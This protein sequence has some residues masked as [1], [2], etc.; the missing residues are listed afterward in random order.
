MTPIEFRLGGGF[1]RHF[2]PPWGGIAIENGLLDAEGDVG[3]A[4]P[5]GEG[6]LSQG[7]IPV[8]VAVGHLPVSR[9]GLAMGAAH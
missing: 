8:V 3:D 9:A 2:S 4:H 1:S 7:F 5:Q 6:N